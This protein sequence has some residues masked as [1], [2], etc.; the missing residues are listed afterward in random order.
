[1]KLNS[2]EMKNDLQLAPC[3]FLIQEDNLNQLAQ[4]IAENAVDL[5]SKNMQPQQKLYNNAEALK[6]L[7]VCQATLQKYRDWGLIEFSQTGRKIYYTQEN[8]DTFLAKNKKEAFSN[9]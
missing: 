7:G 1:M 9:N 3:F 5:L 4:K 2:I 6:Y 8:L